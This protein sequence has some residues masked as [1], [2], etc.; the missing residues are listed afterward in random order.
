[1]PSIPDISTDQIERFGLK[2]TP[3]TPILVK[4]DTYEL[5]R[6]VVAEYALANHGNCPQ[7]IDIPSTPDLTAFQVIR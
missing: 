7:K 4:A 3:N 6:V 2:I 5:V 1:M